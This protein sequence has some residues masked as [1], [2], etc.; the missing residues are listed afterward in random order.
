MKNFRLFCFTFFALC[1]FSS[2]TAMNDPS[3]KIICEKNTD[4]ASAKVTIG[5]TTFSLSD[6][7]PLVVSGKNVDDEF[8]EKV[9][10]L[11]SGTL[12]SFKED[13]PNQNKKVFSY[14]WRDATEEQD[15]LEKNKCV[16][17]EFICKKKNDGTTKIK[18]FR[19]PNLDEAYVLTS[20]PDGKTSATTEP[21]YPRR[22]IVSLNKELMKIKNYTVGVPLNVYPVLLLAKNN[23][24]RLGIENALL[25][26]QR[27]AS[28]P[29]TFD[30]LQLQEILS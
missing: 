6:G 2:A 26:A 5:Q 16:L 19:L 11:L 1:S 18:G 3:L 17:F 28:D 12:R 21:T 14:L 9:E 25:A 29:A 15:F 27:N 13:C 10:D 23:F 20:W 24:E 7:C 4:N 8:C 22:K 30:F